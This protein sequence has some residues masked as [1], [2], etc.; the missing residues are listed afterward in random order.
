MEKRHYVKGLLMGGFAF[1]IWG[2]L[3]LYWK[4]VKAITPYEIFSQR[5]VWSF[6]FVLLIMLYKGNLAKLKGL[7]MSLKQWR[8][9][10]LPAIFISINWLLYIWAVNNDF[11]LETS[12]GYYMNPLILTLFGTVFFKEKLDKYK[13]IGLTLAGVGVIFKTI[14]YGK[15]P[16]IALTL[17]FC[18][19]AYGLL[20]K[21]S[22]LDSLTGLGFETFV[23][24]VPS[25][26]YLIFIEASGEGIIGN[27][28]IWFW[29]LIATSGVVTAIPL[30]LYA[31][32]TKLLPLNVV[33]FLQY[34]APT[35]ALFLGIFVFGEPFGITELIPFVIIWIGLLFFSYSQFK[36]ISAKSIPVNVEN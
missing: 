9:I 7:I 20:K 29:V 24:G 19:A 21:K 31:E 14:L 2:L 6:V 26:F 30:L 32:S 25:L 15:I 5:V 1:V 28:S 10:A 33:G 36:L 22:S 8:K 4:L 23:I 34:I 17:A 11:V 35:I 12:L 3:P 13:I 18:F 27:L 16:I